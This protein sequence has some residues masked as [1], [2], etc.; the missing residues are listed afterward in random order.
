MGPRVRPHPSKPARATRVAFQVHARTL[1]HPVMPIYAVFVILWSSALLVLWRQRC[2]ELA[3]RSAGAPNP[4]PLIEPQKRRRSLDLQSVKRNPIPSLDPEPKP[5]PK[6][7]PARRPSRCS[8]LHRSSREAGEGTIRRSPPFPP[9][10]HTRVFYVFF[11]FCF[12]WGVLHFEQEEQ[13]RSQFRGK[14]RVDPVT[15]A[16]EREYPQW[17]RWATYAMTMPLMAGFTGG[18]LTLMFLVSAEAGTGRVLRLETAKVGAADGACSVA[19]RALIATS[20]LLFLSHDYIHYCAAYHRVY[21]Y[22]FV[23]VLS[24]C[25]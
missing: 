23:L 19:A 25:Q 18:V 16:F 9:A 5:K 8:I 24:S 4:I 22:M 10:T 12:R 7:K 20:L 13:T 14:E 17:R 2:S 6:P 3:Y 15:G 11:V 21:T 1:D